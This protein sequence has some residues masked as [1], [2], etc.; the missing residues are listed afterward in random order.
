MNPVWHLPFSR[1]G[2]E[3]KTSLDTLTP[4]LPC[5]PGFFKKGG[6]GHVYLS[7]WRTPIASQ[8]EMTDTHRV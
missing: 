3:E 8:P 1:N 4:S 2:S 5:I 6:W 7:I